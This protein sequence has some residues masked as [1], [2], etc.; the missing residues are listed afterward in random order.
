[1]SKI[2]QGCGWGVRLCFTLGDSPRDSTLRQDWTKQHIVLKA[3]QI[4]TMQIVSCSVFRKK[5]V[6]KDD[7]G[8]EK[9]CAYW[10]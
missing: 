7:F 8:P 9:N 6:L 5:S 2:E 10:H 4:V 1:M 3:E